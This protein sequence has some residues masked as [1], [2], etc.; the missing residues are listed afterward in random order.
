MKK[1]AHVSAQADRERG[2]S[3]TGAAGRKAMIASPSSGSMPLERKSGELT[4]RNEQMLSARM[5]QRVPGADAFWRY[6][7]GCCGASGVELLFD[8]PPAGRHRETWLDPRHVDAFDVEPG[9]ALHGVNHE[10]KD[11][12]AISEPAHSKA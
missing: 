5:T 6:R 10:I 2:F 12:P 1:L 11:R 4:G 8:G 3:R 9:D 7:E